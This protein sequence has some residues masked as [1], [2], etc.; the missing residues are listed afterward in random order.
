MEVIKQEDSEAI[1]NAFVVFRSMEGAARLIQ[2]F[3]RSSISVACTACCCYCCC[4]DKK[5]Y[6]RKV[7]HKKWLKVEEAVEPALINWEN[8]G[9]SAKARCFRISFLTLVALILLMATTLGILWAKVKENEM[10]S[11][12]VVCNPDVEITQIQAYEDNKL[13]E[14][15]Q[16]NLMYCY[17]RSIL[18]EALGKNENPYDK[19]Q[20]PFPDGEDYCWDWFGSYTLAQSLV[21]L[22]PFSI[23]FI[24]WLSKTILRIMTQFYGY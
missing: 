4:C 13:P 19:L 24:N 9:L 22:V 16:N 17:C 18:W 3:N 15:Q 6:E 1:K 21:Y 23:V 7:F 12:K 5:T 10:S 14:D 2:A 8:L 11:D 20:E